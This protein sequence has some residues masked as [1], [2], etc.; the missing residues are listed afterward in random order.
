MEIL[1]LI[2]LCCAIVGALI[3]AAKGRAGAGAAWGLLLGPIGCLV[4]A[5]APDARAK[6]PACKSALNPGAS[7]CHRCGSFVSV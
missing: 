1:V 5:V 3:G 6:C 2:W 7:E 4:I